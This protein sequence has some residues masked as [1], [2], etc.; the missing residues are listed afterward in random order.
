VC[1][2]T[3]TDNDRIGVFDVCGDIGKVGDGEGDIKVRPT[4]GQVSRET[5]RFWAVMV[6][7]PWVETFDSVLPW[8][9]DTSANGIIGI[10][11][12]SSDK[13]GA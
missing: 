2:E 11:V 10:R 12:G 13:N 5:L 9:G 1:R 7:V 3:G 8:V 6:V 4:I